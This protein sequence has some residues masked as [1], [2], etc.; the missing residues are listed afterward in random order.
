[1]KTKLNR[2]ITVKN[3]QIK[4]ESNTKKENVLPPPSAIKN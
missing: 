4:Q 3:L 2:I 1:M